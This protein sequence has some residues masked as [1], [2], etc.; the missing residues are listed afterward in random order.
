MNRA[1]LARENALAEVLSKYGWEPAYVQYTGRVWKVV[2]P[3]GEYALKN[4]RAP[5]EKLLLLHQMLEQVREEGFPHLL[6]WVKNRDNE[7]VVQVGNE[8]WYAT[9]WKDGGEA[10]PPSPTETVQALAQLHSLTEPLIERYPELPK[11]ISRD[12]I[13][14]WKEKKNQLSEYLETVEKREFASPFDQSFRNLKERLDDTF[15]FAIRGLERFV[16]TDD[17]ALPR[18]AL[19]HRRMHDSNLVWDDEQFYFIDFDHAQV[20]SPVRDLAL[21]IQRF[22]SDRD[23]S[24]TP[25]DLLQAYENSY[26][27]KPKEK[28]LLALYL[29]YPERMMKTLKLYYETPRLSQTEAQTVQRLETEVRQME[30]LQ[31][32]VRQL[33][34][35]QKKNE[36]NKSAT[37]AVPVRTGKKKGKG[38]RKS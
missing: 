10:G 16:E 22:T 32:L 37:A 18:Y 3:E 25:H 23:V 33:W 38:K 30:Q 36:E 29:S 5:R 6:P 17:G 9:P 8:V 21:A 15:S 34:P 31:D 20:E 27:L 24:E 7:P 11:R 4:S 13:Q 19:C 2:M 12:F 28:R 35:G 1:P 26:L 14:K